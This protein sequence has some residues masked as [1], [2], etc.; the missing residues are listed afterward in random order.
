MVDG[1]VADT[2][3]KL[4]A[5]VRASV[6]A[7]VSSDGGEDRSLE[8]IRSHYRDVRTNRLNRLVDSALNASFDLGVERGS[9]GD[10]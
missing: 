8:A 1:L 9:D 6:D 5:D 3:T 10:S 2:A 4:V 7:A